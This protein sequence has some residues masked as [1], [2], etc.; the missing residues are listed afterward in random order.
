[1]RLIASV[2][3][4]PDRRRTSFLVAALAAF[5]TAF[6][7]SSARSIPA[8][9][10]ELVT[11]DVASTESAVINNAQEAPLSPELDF[12]TLLNL[13]D[14]RSIE[15]PRRSHD[16]RMIV[17]PFGVGLKDLSRTEARSQ[18]LDELELVLLERA[19]YSDGESFE[20]RRRQRWFL[21]QR[22]GRDEELTNELSHAFL[23]REPHE[24][25]EI[26]LRLGTW[27][28]EQDQ[29]HSALEVFRAMLAEPNLDGGSSRQARLGIIKSLLKMD[30]LDGAYAESEKFQSEYSPSEPSWKV[31]QARIS[32]GQGD[33]DRAVTVL[34]GVDS[35]AARMWLVYA[36]W[37]GSRETSGVA[38]LRLSTIGIPAGSTHLERTRSAMIAKLSVGQ[39]YA[40]TRASA[41]ERLID[42][43]GEPEPLLNI[44]SGQ[45]LLEAYAHIAG[46]VISSSEL[47]S[48]EDLWLMLWG[49]EALTPLQQRALAVH[50]LWNKRYPVTSQ[51]GYGWLIRHCLSE[52]KLTLLGA[53]FGD[54]GL[55]ATY[56]FLDDDALLTLMDQALRDSD[57]ALA[58]ELQRRVR[59]R[60][61]S[62]DPGSWTVR[63]A[64]IQVLGGDPERGADDLLR[65]LNGLGEMSPDSLDRV[66]Q[67]M[68]DLQFLEQHEL[69]IRLFEA[70]ARL[71]RT[72]DQ[73]REIFYWMGQ[74][75]LALEESAVAAAYFLESAGLSGPNDALWKR[76]ALYQAGL[77]LE[78]GALYEDASRIYEQLMVGA[79]DPKMQAKLQ[80]RLAQ[81]Q[82]ARI[83]RGGG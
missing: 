69:A 53:F 66:M 40:E 48:Q 6:A 81:I 11:P 23:N 38:L 58:A 2:T 1:V 27:L 37:M 67:I 73:K 74:S 75:W 79:V 12:Q 30:D 54:Q 55:L 19:P 82:L 42:W 45:A 78:A 25:S 5:L 60:P 43:G 9:A 8:L 4:P 24:T 22:A 62:I 70:A 7:L 46:S 26:G 76:S 18:N 16:A 33:P 65:W 31:L 56:D 36:Q 71:I 3:L 44:N 21:L 10:E 47:G 51:S 34:D 29:A 28:L 57:F 80:Y 32:L 20:E 39:A 59:K 41:V 14:A 68:F 13:G 63:S 64:R 49:S 61:D 15:I 77:A 35:I 17:E 83:R 50:L 52:G 72:A